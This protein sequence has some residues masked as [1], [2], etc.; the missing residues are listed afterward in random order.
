MRTRKILL[1]CRLG[2]LLLCFS[3]GSAWAQAAAQLLKGYDGLKGKERE[4]KLIEGAKKEGKVVVYSFTAVDQLKPLLE[5]FQK[6]IHSS[7]PSIIERTPRGFSTS[8]RPNPARVKH[9]PTSS[10]SPP[11]KLTPL[12][13]WD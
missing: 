8:S 5:E 6:K 10:T 1:L 4:A 11:V 9:W 13:R 2:I 12:A 3:A 7:L